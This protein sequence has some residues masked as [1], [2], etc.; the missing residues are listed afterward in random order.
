MEVAASFMGDLAPLCDG[1][2]LL[3]IGWRDRLPEFL[4]ILGR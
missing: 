1:I 3:A 2:V 4:D